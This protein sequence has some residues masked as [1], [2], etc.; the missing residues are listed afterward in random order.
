VVIQI[1][2]F[3]IAICVHAVSRRAQQPP[4]LQD[5]P[6]SSRFNLISIKEMIRT[7]DCNELAESASRVDP[8]ES[9]NGQPL[10]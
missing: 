1:S 9:A 8:N 10:L 7:A 2:R 3:A 5:R 4:L 6:I